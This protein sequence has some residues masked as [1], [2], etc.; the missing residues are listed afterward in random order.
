MIELGV[1]ILWFGVGWTVIYVLALFDG[2]VY[3]PPLDLRDK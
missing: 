1:S 2:G 3:P